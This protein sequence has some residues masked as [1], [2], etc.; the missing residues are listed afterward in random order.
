[1]ARAAHL[2]KLPST[3]L[4][5]TEQRYASRFQSAGLQLTKES[6]PN[7]FWTKVAGDAELS[8]HISQGRPMSPLP[9]DAAGFSHELSSRFVLNRAMARDDASSEG[10]RQP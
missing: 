3:L 8:K 6:D 1:M 4:Q 10:S 9:L 5:R 2:R 7:A